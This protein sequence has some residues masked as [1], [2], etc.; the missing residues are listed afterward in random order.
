MKIRAEKDLWSGLMFLGFAAVA[1]YAARNYSVGTAGRMGPGYFPVAL[2]VV[3]AALA[4]LL[5]VRSLI[6]DGAPVGRLRAGPLAVIVVGLALF[7]L[8]VEWLGLVV[9]VAL[10]ATVSALAARES[11]AAEIIGLTLFLV[12]LSVGV[13]AYGLRLPLPVWPNF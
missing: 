12:A 9:S 7:G 4:V 11:T 13:F 1:L 8:T 2:A 3:L 10:V 5:I 6:L